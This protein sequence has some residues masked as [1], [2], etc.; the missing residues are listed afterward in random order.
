MLTGNVFHILCL[1]SV[2]SAFCPL[3]NRV[4]VGMRYFESKQFYC[5]RVK[6]VYH[7]PHLLALNLPSLLPNGWHRH[8][9]LLLAPFVNPQHSI[10]SHVS[11]YSSSPYSKSKWL[12]PLGNLKIFERFFRGYAEGKAREWS[13]TLFIKNFLSCCDLFSKKTTQHIQ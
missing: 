2:S 6:I 11:A 5:K 3:F 1:F 13:K 10:Y 9:L 4:R 8:K 12:F 7:S